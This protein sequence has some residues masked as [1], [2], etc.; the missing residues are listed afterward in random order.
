[1]SGEAEGRAAP[2]SEAA[3]PGADAGVD[4]H[5]GVPLDSPALRLLVTIEHALLYVASLVLLAIGAM[6]LIVSVV[7]TFTSRESWLERLI[8]G[9][10]ALLLFLII[11]EIFVTVMHHLRGGTIQMEFF[12]VIGIIA[13]VR[14][15][16]SIVVRLAVPES[17]LDGQRELMELAV[18]SGAIFLLVVALAVARWSGRRSAA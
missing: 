1:M 2:P 5:L 10:E 9:L 16:L 17:H 14:H 13:L 12:I 11:M 8:D 6:V 15:I 18:D 3:A 7:T 4:A